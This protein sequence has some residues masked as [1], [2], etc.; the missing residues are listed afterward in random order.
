MSGSFRKIS[1]FEDG[2]DR[3]FTMDELVA[4]NARRGVSSG[5]ECSTSGGDVDFIDDSH[6]IEDGGGNDEENGVIIF[7]ETTSV[8]E[9]TTDE[10]EDMVLVGCKEGPQ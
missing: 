2:M 1:N 8:D 9:P 5:W 10:I 6:E 7:Y 3:D 4:A